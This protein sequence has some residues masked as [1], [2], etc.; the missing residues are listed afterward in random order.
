MEALPLLN[1]VAVE[2]YVPLVSVTEPVGA[3]LTVTATDRDWAAVML[4]DAGVTVTVGVVFGEVVVVLLPPPPPQALRARLMEAA[5]RS[6]AVLANCFI[7]I[8]PV[9]QNRRVTTLF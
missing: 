6:A 2:V 9:L 4:D 8:S 7:S 3:P 1:V 5:N